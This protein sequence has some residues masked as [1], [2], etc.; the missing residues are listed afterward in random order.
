M[1]HAQGIGCDE[2]PDCELLTSLQVFIL[3]FISTLILGL[4]T[5]ATVVD[6]DRNMADNAAPLAVG[7]AYTIGMFAEGPYTGGT[8]DSMSDVLLA[9]DRGF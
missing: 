7:L 5:F 1:L 8:L 3:E 6:R 9:C 4:V 2:V